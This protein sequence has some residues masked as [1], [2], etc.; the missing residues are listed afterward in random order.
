VP[1]ECAEN[2]FQCVDSLNNTNAMCIHESW[3]CDGSADC[4]DLSDEWGCE[5][6]RCGSHHFAC[7][8]GDEC[9]HEAWICDGDSDCDDG[10]DEHNCKLG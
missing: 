1:T 3:R 5:E 4:D 10:S 8:S 6:N 2:E 9:I 7:V